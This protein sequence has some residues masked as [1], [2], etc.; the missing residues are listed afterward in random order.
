M[1]NIEYDY[2]LCE[3]EGVDGIVD[4]W[5]VKQ[6]VWNTRPNHVKK[7]LTENEF[8]KLGEKL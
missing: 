6:P 1:K 2:F 5:L 3:K 8:N 4:R 7:E